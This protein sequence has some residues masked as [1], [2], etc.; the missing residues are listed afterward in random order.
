MIV[1]ILADAGRIE[2]DVK[3]RAKADSY[4]PGATARVDVTVRD[5][6]G[7]PTS[8]VLGYWGVDEAL[9]ALAPMTEGH[10]RVFDVL[11]GGGDEQELSLAER[12]DRRVPLSRLN[13]AQ[14]GPD[15]LLPDG[16]DR[17]DAYVPTDASAVCR[18]PC[19]CPA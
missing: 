1:Q 3:A 18:R 4:V 8:A 12:V 2:L 13:L 9:L 6:Q 15:Q 10:E 17:A 5:A 19:P 7:K 14:E 11:G 16:S